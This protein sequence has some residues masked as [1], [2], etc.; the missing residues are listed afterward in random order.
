MKKLF[1]KSNHLGNNNIYI[2]EETIK[3]DLNQNIL[4]KLE[5]NNSFLQNKNNITVD[6]SQNYLGSFNKSPLELPKI[7]N[8]KK[9]INNSKLDG[10][11]RIMIS[12]SST[13]IYSQNIF[14][15]PNNN[16]KQLKKEKT[17]INLIKEEND[18]FISN[19][20]AGLNK[21][22]NLNLNNNISIINRNKDELSLFKKKYKNSNNINNITNIN[23]HIYSNEPQL[24]N[25][26][27][28]RKTANV[29][30]KKNVIITSR[31][32][33]TKTIKPYTIKSQ[34]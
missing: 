8:Q 9:N 13:N 12:N 32:K 7:Q 26:I 18:S 27:L 28:Q 5:L 16:K 3:P 22:N 6:Y 14:G 34:K 19:E 21:K 2:N 15:L 1:L 10:I 29:N 25:D 30:K 11:K 17:Q 20:N 33:N 31:D 4:N 23:I 24:N